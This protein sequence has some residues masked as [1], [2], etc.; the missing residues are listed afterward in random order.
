MLYLPLSLSRIPTGAF[1]EC[2]ALEL[3]FYEGDEK[4]FKAIATDTSNY[5]LL[6][7]T[8]IYNATSGGS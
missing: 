3:V 7:A 8:K 4:A 6:D 1:G 2:L 5:P